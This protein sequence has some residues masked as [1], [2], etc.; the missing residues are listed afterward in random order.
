MSRMGILEMKLILSPQRSDKTVTYAVYGETLQIN[1]EPHD[2][3]GDWVKLEPDNEE[4]SL[5]PTGYLLSGERDPETGEITLTVRAPHGPNAPE[6][7]RFPEP[8]ELAD[9]QSVMFP[10]EVRNA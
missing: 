2:L 7:E 9:E 8:I 6:S 5:E 4:S 10:R 1:G 3:S